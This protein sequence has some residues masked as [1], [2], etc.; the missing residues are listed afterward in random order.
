M[1]GGSHTWN[2]DHE[3]P[4]IKTC[5]LVGQPAIPR[6]DDTDVIYATLNIYAG[7]GLCQISL[8]AREDMPESTLGMSVDASVDGMAIGTLSAPTA[9]STRTNA[10]VVVV[11]LGVILRP[12]SGEGA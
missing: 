10:V 1:Y 11:S 6:D 4:L 12:L 9:E 7:Q 3:A 8:D 2:V 5:H